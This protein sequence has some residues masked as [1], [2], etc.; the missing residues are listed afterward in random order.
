MN[1]VDKAK[2]V[3]LILGLLPIK[4]GWWNAF[5]V[6]RNLA[7]AIN[8]KILTKN[9]PDSRIPPLIPHISWI[10][11]TPT[12]I[13]RIVTLISLIPTLIPRVPTLITHFLTLIPSVPTLIPFVPIINL[14]LFPDSSFRL[15]Q[16]TLINSISSSI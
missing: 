15:L 13:P 1:L 11:C 5:L 14:I 8:T 6:P 16:I 4:A 9:H 2:S 7:E 3:W 10:P 12:P